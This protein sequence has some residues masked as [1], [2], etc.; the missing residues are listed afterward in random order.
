[1]SANIDWARHH[2]KFCIGCIQPGAKQERSDVLTEKKALFGS[3]EI[4]AMVAK[5]SRSIVS[6]L[7]KS[8][9][10]RLAFIGIHSKG[11]PLAHKIAEAV[12]SRLGVEI[13]VAHLDISMYRDDI[14]IRKTL[15]NILPTEVP[16]DLDEKV[17]ILVDDVLSTGRTIRAAL[18]AI[19]DYGRPDLIRLAVLID[20]GGQ[21]FP[22][23]ADFFGA[24]VNVRKNQRVTVL[25]EHDGMPPGVY[26]LPG[27]DNSGEHGK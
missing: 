9:I 11:V 24:K 7:N 6:R 10:K 20:R 23:K 18:D 19:T 2:A 15:P 25:W 4:D 17:I 21:E 5:I 27:K 12:N 8:Q 3:K 14:G 13:P 26:L 16:F 1:M 22:V